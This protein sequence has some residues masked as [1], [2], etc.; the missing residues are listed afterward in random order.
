MRAGIKAQRV[1]GEL[2]RDEAAL[3]RASHHHGEVGLAAGERE[4][5]WGWD[6]LDA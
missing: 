2:A 1:V 3:L 6:E 4:A 5:A